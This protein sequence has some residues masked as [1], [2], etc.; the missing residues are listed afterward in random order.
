MSA[1]TIVGTTTG[2]AGGEA[3]HSVSIPP[4]VAGDLLLI[5]IR[6]S[7]ATVFTSPGGFISAFQGDS[8]TTLF[9]KVAT[10]TE[11]TA[12][13][14]NNSNSTSCNFVTYRIT[15]WGGD[16]TKHFAFSGTAAASG[17]A[18]DAP[19][20]TLPTS[21]APYADTLFI[22][23]TGARSSAGAQT[24]FAP[25]YTQSQ[26]VSGT[27]GYVSLASRVLSVASEDPG[28]SSHA[29][30]DGWVAITIAVAA[31]AN[32]LNNLFFGAGF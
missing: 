31:P 22:V 1:P 19:L 3:T 7:S 18:P 28:A 17:F 9:Y 32:A 15:N 2:A 11:G 25:S 20:L 4:S 30:S 23:A 24:A 12:T 26:I 16:A 27:A 13:P 29:G 5:L 14:I 6:P 21:F 8:R 10:G